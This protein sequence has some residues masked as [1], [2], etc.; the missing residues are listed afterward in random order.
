[1]A[2]AYDSTNLQAVPIG[3]TIPIP[4]TGVPPGYL[5]CDG[6]AISKSVYAKLFTVIGTAH[7]EPIIGGLTFNLPDYRGR[8]LRMLDNGAS[9]DPD[10]ASRLAMNPNGLSGNNIGTVQGAAFFAHNHASVTDPISGQTWTSVY[11]YAST[12]NQVTNT[13]FA[14]ANL[15]N[16]PQF[17]EQIQPAAVTLANRGGSETRPINAAT[18]IMIRYA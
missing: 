17:V 9:R 16:S 3:T 2:T 18:N 15:G 13:N 12:G 7:G 14:A 6:S 10:V 5:L 1:M 4:A 11:G 8:F